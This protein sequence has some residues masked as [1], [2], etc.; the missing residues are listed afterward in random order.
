MHELTDEQLN[1]LIFCIDYLKL[2]ADHPERLNAQ[3]ISFL[4]EL[5]SSMIPMLPIRI[6]ITSGFELPFER[7]VINKSVLGKNKR[8]H[9][10]ENLRYP[11]RSIQEKLDYN[12]AS[13]KGQSI[14]YACSM[15]SLPMTVETRPERGQ[16]ITHSKWKLK[17]G[18]KLNLLS[19]FHHEELAMANPHELL[20]PFNDYLAELR[21]FSPKAQQAI[22]MIY[23]I[24]VRAFTRKVDP[25]N[26]QGYV[27]SALLSELFMFDPNKG[28]DAIYYPSVPNRGMCMN[29]AVKPDSL[30]QKFIM[31]QADEFVVISHPE[32]NKN[33]WWSFHTAKGKLCKEDS[34]ELCW[35]NSLMPDNDPVRDI[36]RDFEIDLS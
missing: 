20:Q 33:M 1:K 36:I 4:R 19:I 28:V 7:L 13:M 24:I 32:P 12:R 26:K 3:Q 17:E 16:L 25:S 27:V 18:E 21:K 14:F 10:L 29:I 22:E 15:G 35:E 8:V 2:H 11:P 9:S 23:Q 34:L 5:L 31:T 6:E 30:D